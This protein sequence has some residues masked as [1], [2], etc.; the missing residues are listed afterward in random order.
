MKILAMSVVGVLAIGAIIGI[1]VGAPGGHGGVVPAYYDCQLFNITLRELPTVAEEYLIEHNQS[2]NIIYES[3]ECPDFIAVI[4]AIQGDGFNPLWR[5]VQITFN[6]GFPCE[7]FCRDDD[8]VA[9]AA[10]G[11]IT[12]TPTD[13]VYICNVFRPR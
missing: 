7:Q 2:M 3:D 9:A 12:L 1:A 10:A 11:E 5:E 8:I 6:E 4:D 13:E